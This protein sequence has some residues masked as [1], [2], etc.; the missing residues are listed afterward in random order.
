MKKEKNKKGRHNAGKILL[1]GALVGGLAAC[2]VTV[3]KKRRAKKNKACS[4]STPC[5]CTDNTSPSKKTLTQ[6][7]DDPY[8][9]DRCNSPEWERGP[10][11]VEPCKKTSSTN[12]Q[13]ND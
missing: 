8:E 2:F 6:N 7:S 13:K 3:M 4:P 5:S 12:A 9:P 1:I 10:Q 11:S